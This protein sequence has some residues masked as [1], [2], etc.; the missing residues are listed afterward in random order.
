M[1]AIYKRFSITG[2]NEEIIAQFNIQAIESRKFVNNIP[3][4]HS[5]ISCTS[6]DVNKP[7]TSKKINKSCLRPI[8]LED[9][10][11]GVNRGTYL[12]VNIVSSTQIYVATSVIIQDS[13]G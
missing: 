8:T 5:L 1:E 11:Q 9:M 13:K 4:N 2:S 7:I 6:N 3:P 12:K 10:L